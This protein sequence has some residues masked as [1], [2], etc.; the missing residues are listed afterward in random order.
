MALCTYKQKWSSYIGYTLYNKLLV[1]SSLQPT[2][3]G[4]GSDFGELLVIFPLQ[5]AGGQILEAREENLH[6]F[7]IR[8]GTSLKGKGN[9]ACVASRVGI[10]FLCHL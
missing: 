9:V 1:I 6:W 5:V 3:N 7:L 10:N 2:G 4:S 8:V